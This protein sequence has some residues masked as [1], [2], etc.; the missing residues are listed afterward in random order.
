MRRL[1]QFRRDRSQRAVERAQPGAALG[2][3]VATRREGA[4]TAKTT[5]HPPASCWRFAFP[6]RV[7]RNRGNG[8][9]VLANGR[10]AARRA[11]LGA[12][13]R[14]LYRGRRTDRHGGAAAASCWRRR[15]RKPRSRQRFADQIETT[16]EISFDRG[17][18]ALARPAQADAARDHAVGSA[19]GAVA[20][21]GDRASLGRWP[22]RRRPRQIA[23]VESR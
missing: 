22:D 16:D 6:D 12:G 19:D 11:D 13:A 10:G 4:P 2:A 21:G 17:A 7:A 14:A 18:M 3:Q 8:S 5:R 15:S 23:V 9:F 20:V 1:D